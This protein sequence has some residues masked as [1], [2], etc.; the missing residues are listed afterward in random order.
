VLK[1]L[2]ENVRRKRPQL[3]R[4]NSWFFHHDNALAHASL[5]ISDFLANMKTTVL[6][7]PPYSP[8]LA[9]PDFLISQTEIHFERTTISDDSRDYVKF[10]DGATRHQEEAYQNCFQKWERCWKR[11]VK[12]VG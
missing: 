7:Q 12:A 11:C 5:P 1:Y 3:W 4:K 6:P 9:P 8:N 2:R 10:A